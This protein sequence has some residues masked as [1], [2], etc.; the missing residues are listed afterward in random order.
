MPVNPLFESLGRIF[1]VIGFSFLGSIAIILVGVFLGAEFA[2]VIMDL[3]W[4]VGIAFFIAIAAAGIGL[5]V[6]SFVK[7]ESAAAHVGVAI[8]LANYFIGT[9]IPY[10]ELPDLLKPIARIS[11]FSSGNNM[12]AARL[13]GPEFI[14][15]NPWNPF[16]LG[17]M[18]ALSMSL[19]IT[20][21]MVYCRF[22]WKR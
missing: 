16:D 10:A 13:L 18:I 14:G 8:V 6:G 12:M 1:T 17:L 21:L 3:L 11:P 4:A 15:Y 22:C 9:A 19:L 7:T 20:G 2:V 5:M